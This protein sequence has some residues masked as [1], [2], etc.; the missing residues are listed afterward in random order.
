MIEFEHGE[1]NEGY[2]SYEHMVIQMEDCRDVLEII[3][4]DL[5]M[6]YKTDLLTDHSANH[7]K[8]RPDRLNAKSMSVGFGGVQPKMRP[9]ELKEGCVGEYP[10]TLSAFYDAMCVA[11]DANKQQADRVRCTY[12]G[13]ITTKLPLKIGNVHSNVFTADDEGPM[14]LSIEERRKQK[15]PVHTKNHIEKSNL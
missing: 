5:G 3:M 4:R 15:F 6:R 11:N 10:N 7:N 1:N 9:S 12:V 2:W 13:D 8:H 14:Y